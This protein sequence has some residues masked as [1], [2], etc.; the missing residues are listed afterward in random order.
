M[1]LRE[2]LKRHRIKQTI[3]AEAL[4][5]HPANLYRYDNLS[6]RSIKEIRIISEAT[7]IGMSE[8][9]GEEWKIAAENFS[10]RTGDVL[11]EMKKAFTIPEETFK[12]MK[13]IQENKESITAEMVRSAQLEAENY[14]LERSLDLAYKEID[15]LKLII[16][17]QRALLQQKG[18]E[19]E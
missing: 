17:E 10:I 13:F 4:K 11:A 2:I 12:N 9:L 6:E 15:R 14:L 16:E 19:A 7:G 18:K 1:T 5:V 8:L 3:V